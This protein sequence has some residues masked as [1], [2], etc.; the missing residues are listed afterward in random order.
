MITMRNF[1]ANFKGIYCTSFHD[2]W[3]IFS[4]YSQDITENNLN[5]MSTLGKEITK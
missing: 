1:R 5:I 2:S 3:Q 4:K